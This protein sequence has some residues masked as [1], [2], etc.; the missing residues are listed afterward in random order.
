MQKA[1]A[2]FAGKALRKFW[3]RLSRSDFR[4]SVI[5]EGFSRLLW[6]SAL[7]L[8]YLPRPSIKSV[9]SSLSADYRHKV[10]GYTRG[11]GNIFYAPKSA[12]ALM[13]NFVISPCAA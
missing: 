2:A 8:R 1:L 13:R 11:C 5:V 10:Y 12:R 9:Y 7:V 6:R 4:K 3:R